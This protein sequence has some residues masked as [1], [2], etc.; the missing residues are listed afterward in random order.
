MEN[1]CVIVFTTV[2][3][4]GQADEL[5]RSI[6][7]AGLA[8]C[9]QIETIRSVYRWKGEVCAEPEIRLTIKTAERQYAALEH[10][11]KSNHA[12]E[13]PEIVKV[14]IA[15]GSREYLAWIDE[16]LG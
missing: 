14:A 4:E 9:V 11:I 1:N 5:A 8:A 13:T 10:H 15:G 3:T 12:Y 16:C 2:A 6:V 7:S